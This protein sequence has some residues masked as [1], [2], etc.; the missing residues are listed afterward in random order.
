[1]GSQPPIDAPVFSI[2][3][4]MMNALKSIK[5]WSY[6]LRQCGKAFTVLR[7]ASVEVVHSVNSTFGMVGMDPKAIN[8]FLRSSLML[9]LNDTDAV[10][11]LNKMVSCSPSSWQNWFKQM[12]H[13]RVDPV[14]YGLLNKHFPPAVLAMKMV[15]GSDDKKKRKPTLADASQENEAL[16][17]SVTSG[18]HPGDISKIGKLG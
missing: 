13:K 5:K 10:A 2:S 6:F 1:M 16:F 12:S 7:Q 8:A 15:E 11:A 18:I 9:D 3:K 14:W 4:G 17:L